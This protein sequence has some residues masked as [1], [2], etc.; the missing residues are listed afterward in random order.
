[1]ATTKARTSQ[2]VFPTPPKNQAYLLHLTNHHCST[3][4]IHQNLPPTP[5]RRPQTPLPHRRHHSH[6]PDRVRPHL[7]APTPLRTHQP[8]PPLRRRH[9]P[10]DLPHRGALLRRV[11]LDPAP[12]RR[13]RRPAAQ[14][15]RHC[16]HGDVGQ[17]LQ[18]RG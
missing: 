12:R 14:P 17:D 2:Y 5:L 15:D 1:M 3:T 13:H 18:P 16:G 7:R 4:Q 8:R 9:P 10:R 11:P 6:A